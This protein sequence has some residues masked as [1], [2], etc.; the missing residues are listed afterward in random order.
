MYGEVDFQQA[1]RR[2]KRCG[3]CLGAALLPLAAAYVLGAVYD[4]YALMLASLLAAFLC[5]VPAC[6]FALLPAL[7]Y[8]RFLRDMQ[9]G[10]RRGAECT[11]SR[12]EEGEQLQDGV[13]VRALH[14]TLC[15]GDSRIFYVN[16]SK[17]NLLPELGRRVRLLSY[18]R[19]VVEC[20][21]I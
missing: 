3:L 7:R 9:K 17:L 14:V 1:N 13:R 16:V 5:C 18:G 21:E 20:E 12:L 10:L 8:R 11:L 6:D 19:H 15:N 4:V 2:V